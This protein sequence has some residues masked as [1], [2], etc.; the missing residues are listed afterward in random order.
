MRSGRI[1]FNFFFDS[2]HFV[3]RLGSWRRR[4]LRVR[5]RVG[6]DI[7]FPARLHDHGTDPLLYKSPETF[8]PPGVD[9]RIDETISEAQNSQGTGYNYPKIPTSFAVYIFALVDV[10]NAG[11][12]IGRP[13][14]QEASRRKQDHF[15]GLPLARRF[16]AGRRILHEYPGE[17]ISLLGVCLFGLC[18]LSSTAKHSQIVGRRIGGVSVVVR[19][20][21]VCDFFD[22]VVENDRVE[23]DDYQDWKD[24]S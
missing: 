8:V 21:E 16:D 18:N 9:Y 2:F 14:N 10:N 12:K 20:L 19:V 22:C 4:R 7:I 24:S 3:T 6:D 23:H 13:S 15:D 5:I 11:Y 17:N 1:H